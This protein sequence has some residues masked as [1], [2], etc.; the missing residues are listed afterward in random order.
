MTDPTVHPGFEW[1]PRDYTRC[2][3]E[4]RS[5]VVA[6]SGVEVALVNRRADGVTAAPVAADPMPTPLQRSA[7]TRTARS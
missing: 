2:D 4:E 3:P 1:R 6:G 5:L 7:A